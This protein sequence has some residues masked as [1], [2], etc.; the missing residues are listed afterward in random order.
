[1][2][3]G[4][5]LVLAAL[6]LAGT[7]SFACD[8]GNKSNDDK[9]DKKEKGKDKKK[10]KDK[11]KGDDADK[12]GPGKT[13]DGQGYQDLPEAQ[14][15]VVDLGFRPGK[16][17]L[18]FPNGDQDASGNPLEYPNNS[19]G[20]LDSIGVQKLC[21]AR[22]AC[23]AGAGD[24]CQL[25]PA[26][27]Q[28]IDQV[29]RGMNG[30]QCEG[31]AV[32]GL[33]L[34]KQLDRPSAFGNFQ[35]TYDLDR[36]VSRSPIGYYF[37]FQIINPVAGYKAQKRAESTPAREL[38]FIIEHL[39]KQEDPVVVGFRKEGVGGHAVVAYA[40]EDRGNNVFWVRI[41][42]N[43]FPGVSRA[44][45]IDKSANT[46]RYDV[47]A[48]NPG[49]PAQP[50]N[51]VAAPNTIYASPLSLRMND[52][53]CGFLGEDNGTRFVM[54]TGQARPL[55][56]DDSGNAIGYSGGQ[57]V[58]DIPGAKLVEIDAFRFGGKPP[59][60]VYLLPKDRSYT[61][62]LQD[63][64]NGTI[65]YYGANAALVVENIQI[66]AGQK[67]TLAIQ[68]D[69]FGFTYTPSGDKKPEV[70]LSLDSADKDFLVDMT[71]LEG[72]KAL[73]FSVDPSSMKL[74]FPGDESAADFDFTITR[75]ASS[76]AKKVYKK[77]DVPQGRGLT[78]DGSI[79][80]D[81]LE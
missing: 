58:N 43:N 33:S 50:W 1:M 80:L 78:G 52:A 64:A 69:G 7:F 35:T 36:E 76:G 56:R 22:K 73:T 48:T 81:D 3:P 71:S 38:D 74:D 29:N 39:Q 30:G 53:D 47:A 26:A 5:L 49:V 57:L 44:I 54:A 75:F 59:E 42:D 40:V 63:T 15:Y 23:I 55:I 16:D 66:A 67:D 72:G 41:W 21:G 10:D 46:W 14:S 37:A 9:P 31:F 17:G 20:H 77:A 12:A 25:K 6:A 2:A 19:K 11:K 34:F 27:A 79:E 13:Y 28:F 62:E 18:K 61:I 8:L 65:G 70:A 45:E 68:A 60:P 51:G 4:R 24:S 32:F